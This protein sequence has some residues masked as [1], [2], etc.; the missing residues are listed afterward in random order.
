MSRKFT[1]EELA[2]DLVT[3]AK[4][5][6]HHV[7]E[8]EARQIIIETH[9][10]GCTGLKMYEALRALYKAKKKPT[11]E[12]IE[13]GGVIPWLSVHE[14]QAHAERYLSNEDSTAL[15][16]DEL[17]QAA[18]AMQ[19]HSEY[20]HFAKNKVFEQVYTKAVDKAQQEGR[21]PRY[22][23]S[24]GHDKAQRD[25]VALEAFSGG[26][27]DEEMADNYLLGS[28]LETSYLMSKGYDKKI[29][30]SGRKNLEKLKKMVCLPSTAPSAD[31]A[32]NESR[33][34]QEKN[35]IRSKELAKE[36]LK[37]EKFVKEK[38]QE[39]NI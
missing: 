3:T 5:A 26:L 1:V 28:E 20:N 38:R 24:C 37:L 31:D 19:S 30:A 6:G 15:V 34:S 25:Q 22:F 7:C 17:M 35:M 36:L 16:F 12:N 23:L 8:I 39:A 32:V 29:L 13:S 10:G 14:A 9:K 33:T 2:N 27:I 18:H 4:H 21:E 11:R